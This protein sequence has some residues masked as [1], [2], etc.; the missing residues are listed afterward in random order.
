ML[1]NNPICAFKPKY[2]VSL[3]EKKGDQKHNFGCSLGTKKPETRHLK[4]E[5]LVSGRNMSEL[6]EFI[7]FIDH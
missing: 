4:G 2:A 1:F 3:T 7:G 5:S 6:I